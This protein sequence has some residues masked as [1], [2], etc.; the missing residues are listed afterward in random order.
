ML[1]L[2]RQKDDAIIIEDKDGNFIA[3]V[4]VVRIEGQKV[5]L[6]IEADKSIKIVRDELKNRD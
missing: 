5:R 6:G 2:S 3:Q 4:T 1:V